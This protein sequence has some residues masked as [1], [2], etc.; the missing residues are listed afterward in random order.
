[1]LIL[2]IRKGFSEL[3]ESKKLFNATVK[4]VFFHL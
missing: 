2:N 4:F 1:M 3:G